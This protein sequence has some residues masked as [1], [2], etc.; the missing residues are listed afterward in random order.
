MVGSYFLNPSF[1]KISRKEFTLLCYLFASEEFRVSDT[2]RPFASEPKPGTFNLGPLERRILEEIW[3]RKSLTVRELL[4][5]GKIRLAY[6]TVMTTL[7]RLFKKGLLDR[8]EE[9]RAF[10]YSA[11]CAP[12]DIPRFV[13]VTNM[14]RWIESAASS[15]LPLSYFVEAVSDHDVKLLDELRALVEMKRSELEKR[16]DQ[17]KNQNKNDKEKQC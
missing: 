13:A 16:Q 12:A 4:A 3:T 17:N 1:A 11:R 8:T 2:E 14:R 10:R 9:G 5:E 15:F 7:D 6:T